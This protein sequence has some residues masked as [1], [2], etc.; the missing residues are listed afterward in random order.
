M[1]T[2][3]KKVFGTNNSNNAFLPANSKAEYVCANSSITRGMTTAPMTLNECFSR[4][5]YIKN[6][7]ELLGLTS[8]HVP[9]GSS[10]G[11]TLYAFVGASGS[12][13]FWGGATGSTFDI[14][15]LAAPTDLYLDKPSKE[16]ELVQSNPKLGDD[17]LG[18][19]WESPESSFSCICPYVGP[20][21]DAYLKHRLNVA[22]FWGTSKYAPVLRKEFLD[23]MKYGRQCEI[24]VAGDFLLKVGQ[25]IE[26]NVNASSG[27]PYMAGNSIIN[28]K[29]W[30]I[31][32]KHVV[33]SGGTHETRLRI[34][35]L[36]TS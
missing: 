8:Y 33:N 28:G 18:C 7:S 6:L 36:P 15:T 20:K 27:Y 22:T 29:Y 5:P 31:S 16:C 1:N 9:N 35:Q 26:L 17:W 13:F 23:E 32:V 25:V 19:M 3:Q 11:V 21:Y 34:A 12:T 24:T 14:N 10:V 30:I 2:G 4:F